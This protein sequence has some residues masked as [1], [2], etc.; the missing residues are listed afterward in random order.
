MLQ[1]MEIQVS[2]NESC[3]ITP[4]EII[5]DITYV[6][7]GIDLDPASSLSANDIVCANRIFTVADDMLKQDLTCRTLFM[8]PPFGKIKNQSKAGIFSLYV[9]NQYRLGKIKE[10]GVILTMSRHGYDWFEDL[11]DLTVS[12]TLKKR[13][14]F[15]NPKTM[16]QGGQAKTAQTLLCFGN[17]K[18]INRFYERFDNKARIFTPLRLIEKDNCD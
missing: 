14:R 4:P 8:N 7:D 15:I 5:A 6:L 2:S 10:G 13:L 18:I 1:S 17:D 12:A 11:L 16:K 3:W 9:L